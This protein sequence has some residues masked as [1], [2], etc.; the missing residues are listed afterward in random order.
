M[1]KTIKAEL[2]VA[3][4]VGATAKFKNGLASANR[5]V[6]FGPPVPA[7]KSNAPAV[8]KDGGTTDGGAQKAPDPSP[9]TGSGKVD[10]TPNVPLT[11]DQFT[12]IFSADL[13]AQ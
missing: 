12:K 2:I 4:G 13:L 10:P 1:A 6:D 7:Q 5:R 3:T 9:K 11:D 8:G